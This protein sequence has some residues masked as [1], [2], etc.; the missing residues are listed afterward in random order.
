MILNIDINN[1]LNVGTSDITLS[2]AP[3]S[4]YLTSCDNANIN[5]VDVSSFIETAHVICTNT[6]NFNI[7]VNNKYQI[8]SKLLIY[9]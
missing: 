3:S 8:K 7:V 6:G 1:I 2:N 5:D 9:T 4:S